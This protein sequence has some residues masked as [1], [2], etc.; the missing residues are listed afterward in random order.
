MTTTDE[1]ILPFPRDADEEKARRIMAEAARLAGLPELERTH[2]MNR[3]AEQYVE[4]FGITI[5]ELKTYVKIIV[6][7]NE[8]K[9]REEKGEQHRREQRIEKQRIASDRAEERKRERDQKQIVKDAERKAKDKHSALA[10]IIK[11]PSAQHDIKLAELAKR[12]GEDPAILREELAELIDAERAALPATPAEWSAEPWG[13]PVPTAAL[14][15]QLIDKISKHIAARPDELLTIALWV[16]LTWVHEVAASYSPYLTL[17]SSDPDC[18]K[19]TVLTVLQFLTPK[20]YLCAELTGP[21]LFR[22]VDREKPTMLADDVD[23]LF[24]RK[25]DL[26]TIFNIAW[27]R[28]ARISRQQKVGGD[29]MTV[30]FDPFCPKAVTLIGERLPPALRSRCIVIKLWPKK[31]DDKVEAFSLIGDDECAVLQRKLARWSADNAVGLKTAQPL[32]PAGFGNRVA[33]NWLL[34]LAIAELGNETWAQRA[35]D[36]GEHLTRVRA[37]PS[38]RQRLLQ[39]VAK[40]GADGRKWIYSKALVAELT[41]DPTSP[42]TEYPGFRHHGKI[43]E[44]QVAIL[45]KGLDIFPTLCGPQRLSG[46]VLADFAKAFAH[47]P[48]QVTKRGREDRTRVKRVAKA[49]LQSRGKGRRA[50]KKAR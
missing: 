9:A 1:N 4:R 35:R 15:Q 7:D 11:L 38:W 48:V 47:F 42:W 2:W 22:F 25:P 12:L 27:T 19:T 24:V 14:L 49:K 37:E 6:N 17:T 29:W 41:Q 36:A 45:L 16:M 8:K 30:W 33:N 32:L 23:D 18:G 20:A 3:R 40:L 39:T 26:R 21:S 31:T 44:R 50:T 13:D 34:L 43:T 10:T 46:Y 28:G 5:E